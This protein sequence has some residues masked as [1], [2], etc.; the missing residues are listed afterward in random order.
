MKRRMTEKLNIWKSQTTERLPLLIYGARQVGKTHIVLEFG[1]KQFANVI[2]VNFEQ[3]PGLIPYFEGDIAPKRIINVLEK[4]YQKP[5][6]AEDTLIF[7]DEIQVCERALTSLKY[8]AE[9]GP[10]YYVI[11]AGS[12]LGVAVNRSKFSFPV[13]KVQMETLY[14]LDFEEFLWAR[15]QALLADEIKRC[16]DLSLA[17]NDHLHKEALTAYKEYLIVGGMPAAVKASIA[18]VPSLTEVEV[19]RA[20][21]NAYIADMAKYATSAESVKIK[22]A[23]ESIP[24]QLAKENSKFQYKLIKS[25]GRAALYGDSIDWL[26]ASCVVLKCIKC[27]HGFMPLMAYQDLSSFK[28]YM[29]DIGLLSAQSGITLQSLA[30]NS[31]NQFSGAL[32]ENYV[33]QALTAKGFT[34]HYWNSKNTAEVDFLI[35]WNGSVIPVEVKAAEN[36]RSRSLTVYTERYKP[37]MAIRISSRNFGFENGIKSIPLYAIFAL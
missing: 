31:L 14:P 10:E 13:G 16:C 27:D 4:Y 12:L 15:G 22:S 7:F 24:T 21:L 19:R 8:F 20:I 18:I 33:A 17:I 5:I 1:H 36:N 3:D 6:H 32:T 34:L 9:S 26:V 37:Q 23:F 28:L 30:D 25:G 35:V 29:S 2:Y 11:A